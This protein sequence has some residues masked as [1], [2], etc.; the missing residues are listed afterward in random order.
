MAVIAR[1]IQSN[2]RTPVSNYMRDAFNGLPP[3]IRFRLEGV[4]PT[5]NAVTAAVPAVTGSCK[6]S[7][8]YACYFIQPGRLSHPTLNIRRKQVAPPGL[9]LDPDTRGER[10]AVVLQGAVVE[11]AT[12]IGEGHACIHVEVPVD[13]II[14]EKG[15]LIVFG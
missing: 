9:P 15:A 14:D 6:A 8:G 3:L 5:K 11:T 2:L 7:R 12:L 1:C 13:G 10:K 4:Y